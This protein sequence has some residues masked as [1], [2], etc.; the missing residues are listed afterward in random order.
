[1]SRFEPLT[2][3]FEVK[4]VDF[5]NHQFGSRTCPCGC[6]PS[7]ATNATFGQPEGSPGRHHVDWS[8]K[9]H[10]LKRNCWS[11]RHRSVGGQ[12]AGAPSTKLERLNI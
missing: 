6:R 5:L 3:D 2:R 11:H 12:W 9:L 4:G 1:L 7:Q 10:A 8:R